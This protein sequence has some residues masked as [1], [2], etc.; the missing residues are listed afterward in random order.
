[1]SAVVHF[2]LQMVIV[3][4][5]FN[6]FLNVRQVL[7]RIHPL[8]SSYKVIVARFYAHTW[9]MEGFTGVFGHHIKWAVLEVLW[10]VQGVVIEPPMLDLTEG[11]TEHPFLKSRKSIHVIKWDTSTNQINRSHYRGVPP[12]INTCHYRDVPPPQI[13]TC[14]CRGVPPHINTWIL[15]GYTPPPQTCY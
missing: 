15:Q 13:N 4:V 5:N 3:A 2:R 7:Q 10:H 11:T 9:E 1:M 12:Q 14:H 8:E 6:L